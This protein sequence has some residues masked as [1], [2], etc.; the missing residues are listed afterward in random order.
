[1]AIKRKLMHMVQGGTCRWSAGSIKTLSVVISDCKAVDFLARLALRGPRSLDVCTDAWRA[2]S[3]CLLL[4]L[5]TVSMLSTR[6]ALSLER[7][8]YE[9]GALP[10]RRGCQHRK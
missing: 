3:A 4:V 5:L 1:M 8:S 7:C 10:R 2:G 6:P 9:D